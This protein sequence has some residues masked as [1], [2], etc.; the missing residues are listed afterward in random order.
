VV[1]LNSQDPNGIADLQVLLVEDD[2]IMRLSLEDRMRLEG[3]SARS[4]ATVAD[5]TRV[6]EDG[7]VDLVVTDIRLPDGNGRDLLEFVGTRLPGLPVVLMTAYG[8]VAEA[9]A[10]VQA[11]ATDYLTK[12]FETADFIDRVKGALAHIADSRVALSL[13]N[14]EGNGARAGE[15]FL[16]VSSVMRRIERLVARLSEVDSSVLI[17]GESGVGKEVVARLLHDN[18][19]RAEGPMICINCAAIPETLFESELFGHER[20]AFTG[21]DRRRVGKFEQAN[22]GT[23]FL[24]EVAEIPPH[25]QVKLLRALQEREVERLGGD[26]AIPFDVRILAATQVDL[27]AAVAEARFR[28]DLFWRLNVIHIDI[29]PL[30]ERKADIVHLANRFVAWQAKETGRPVYGLS[31]EAELALQNKDFPGNVRE[32]KNL[33]ERAVALAESRIIEPSLFAPLCA[34]STPALASDRMTPLKEAVENAER[35]TIIEA[36]HECDWVIG[37]TADALAISRKS[38]WEKMKRYEIK[39]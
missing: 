38:L 34:P 29:P 10:L 20:G 9:V 16:G 1:K 21:A 3:L 23:L 6:I 15:G 4:A 35:T 19:R 22:G 39:N 27:D 28:S 26:V 30:R 18:S 2:E 31:A 17:T 36:L 8:S 37:R 13:K 25:V 7:D 5:A 11:G 12:P 32:L 33:I 14:V 24:D